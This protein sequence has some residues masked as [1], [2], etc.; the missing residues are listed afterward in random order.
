MVEMKNL[1]QSKKIIS[2]DALLS[3]DVTSESNL[4]VW[5]DIEITNLLNLIINCVRLVLSEEQL[6]RVELNKKHGVK[7]IVLSRKGKLLVKSIEI[8]SNDG[9]HL[10]KYRLHPVLDVF[11][12]AV[13][14]IWPDGLD[15]AVIPE[16][17]HHALFLELQNFSKKIISISSSLEFKSK[18]YDFCRGIRKN[19]QSLNF[20]I[21]KIFN[22]YLRVKIFRLDLGYKI[23]AHRDDL[24]LD[25][26]ETQKHK[27]L[28]FKLRGKEKVFEGL[29]GYVWKLRYFPAKGFFWHILFLYDPQSMISDFDYVKEMRRLWSKDITAGRGGCIDCS[30][31]YE[32]YKGCGT[33]LIDGKDKKKRDDLRRAI[34]YFAQVDCLAK[35]RLP[36][37]GRSLGQ[38]GL[39]KI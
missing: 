19:Q 4:L 22:R 5:A 23:F 16:E 15:Y 1:V 17:N 14:D 18:K 25:F 33:G 8:I 9:Y 11:V 24:L 32:S 7:N 31:W 38:S 27:I 2:D 3:L 26:N 29:I 39:P 12:E 13:N 37:N 30:Y 28:F 36:S 10:N 35:L 20:F 21:D 6:F 34:D